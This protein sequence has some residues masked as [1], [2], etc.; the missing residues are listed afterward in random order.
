MRISF[1]TK[2][3]NKME[4]FEDLEINV[5]SKTVFRESSD[6]LRHL[7]TEVFATKEELEK[8]E[9][10]CLAFD[11]DKVYQTEARIIPIQKIKELIDK[12]EA[13]GANFVAID[14][15]CDHGEY[16]V[17]GY[18][19]ERMS[20]EE[21]DVLEAKKAEKTK[22]ANEAKIKQLEEQIKKIKGG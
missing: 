22:K 17:Y 18:H 5:K 12:A 20:Q 4:E 2:R 8:Y 19:V 3:K 13:S 15:H 10:V 11:D 16:D 14:Y 6:E 7:E 1:L 21:I 9:Y